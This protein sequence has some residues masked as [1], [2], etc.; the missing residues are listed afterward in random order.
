MIGASA[1][2][3]DTQILQASAERTTPTQAIMDYHT[4]Q[5]NTQDRISANLYACNYNLTGVECVNSTLTNGTNLP[6]PP[7]LANSLA[8]GIFIGFIILMIVF[9]NCMVVVAVIKDRHLKQALQNRFIVS[10]AV[11]DMLLGGLIMPLSLHLEILKYWALG[12]ILCDIWLAIDVF[13]CTA[14][15]LSL[16]VVSL[17]RYWSVTKAL[18]YPQLRTSRK[19][20]ISIAGIWLT[21]ALVSLP[22]LAGWKSQ[23][24]PLQCNLSDELGYIIYSLTISFYIPLII[25]LIAYGRIFLVAR[26]L[27]QYIIFMLAFKEI[28]LRLRARDIFLCFVLGNRS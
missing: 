8:A 23:D 17:D 25:I 22:P 24:D 13:L 15:T 4:Q 1:L 11:A 2:G 12:P 16:V 18:E 5:N 14:S 7:E 20:N 3:Q 6:A 21:S 26:R 27:V 28:A 10:L 19:V 9:G